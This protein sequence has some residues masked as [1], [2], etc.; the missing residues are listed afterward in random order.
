ME[1]FRTRKEYE[2][3]ICLAMNFIADNLNRNLSLDEIAAEAHFPVSIFIAFFPRG[4]AK[5]WL[6]S[7]VGCGWRGRP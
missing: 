3:R 1:S 4:W 5:P 7:P 6:N 2:R